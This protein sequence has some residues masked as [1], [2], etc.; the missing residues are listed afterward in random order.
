MIFIITN[1]NNFDEW[2]TGLLVL[3]YYQHRMFATCGIR[4]KIFV[5]QIPHRYLSDQ[6]KRPEGLDDL[7]RSRQSSWEWY[8]RITSENKATYVINLVTSLYIFLTN[9]K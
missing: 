1:T 6:D 2:R 4:E 9:I 5:S 3:M 7:G 8:C